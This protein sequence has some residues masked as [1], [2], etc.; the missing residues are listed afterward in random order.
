MTQCISLNCKK[1]IDIQTFFIQQ[2]GNPELNNHLPQTIISLESSS[3][4]R[5]KTLPSDFH[6][7]IKRKR[8]NLYI[9]QLSRKYKHCLICVEI[10]K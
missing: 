1:L 6:A 3:T 9:S 2:L 8:A 10:S 5:S 4:S 7:Q